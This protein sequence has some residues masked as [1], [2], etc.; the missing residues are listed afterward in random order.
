MV[1]E[2]LKTLKKQS[3]RLRSSWI[4]VICAILFVLTGCKQG[5]DAEQNG[6]NVIEQVSIVSEAPT[7][8]EV[9]AAVTRFNQ[10]MVNPTEKSIKDLCAEGLTYGHSS[11]LIQNR[12]EF[13]DDII[14]G[15]FDFSSVKSP[16]QT[17]LIS[18]NTAIARHIFLAEA[19]N[20]GTPITIRL[21]NIQVYKKGNDGKLKLFG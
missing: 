14:N 1:E 10:A 18:G 8:N 7:K 21:G 13:I 19:T 20:A 9:A 16:E 15:S 11:G 2:K 4:L 12:A 17:I 3:Y 6:T 5:K